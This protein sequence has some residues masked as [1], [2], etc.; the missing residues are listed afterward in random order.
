MGK[1]KIGLLTEKHVCLLEKN[2]RYRHAY[3]LHMIVDV[4]LFFVEVCLYIYIF[5][6][7]SA[8]SCFVIL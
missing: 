6:S 4:C 3:C 7:S 2:F 8:F 5:A 1:K